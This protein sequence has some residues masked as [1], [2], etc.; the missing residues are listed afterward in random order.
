M[1]LPEFAMFHLPTRIIFGNGIA[2]DFSVELGELKA[3]KLF[4]VT[5]KTI[6]GLGLVDYMVKGLAANGIEVQGIF[7]EV[8]QDSSVKVVSRIAE[9]FN[10]VS[11]DSFLTIGGGS[12]IDSAKG[13]N[14]IAK[15]GGDLIKDYSGS[16]VLTEPLFPLIVVPTTAGTGSEVTNA[17]VIYDEE[18]KTKL[19]FI[20]RFIT[21]NLAVLDPNMTKSMPP[22]ITAFTGLDALTHAVEAFIDVDA[23]PFSDMYAKEAI[24]IITSHLI[25]ACINGDNLEERGWMAIG[26]TLAGVAFSHSECG[27]VHGIAHSL[28]AVHR[29]PHGIANAIILPYGM[30]YNLPSRIEKFAEL[31]K[32]LNV[33]NKE[34]SDEDNGKLAIENI[35]NFEEGV[36]KV[37]DLPLKLRDVGVLKENFELIAEKTL[38][39]GTSIYNPREETIEGVIEILNKAY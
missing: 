32:V 20:D 4:I 14:I 11:A 33:Y 18:T 9:L 5:D 19:E 36:S 13:A 35:R 6:M 25:N 12:V 23:T 27:I 30:E 38:Q 7:D 29:V 15:L 16:N 26:A 31:A 34:L 1:K 10:E 3:H 39:D 8:P 24:S 28:G 17:A 22:K 2:K 37:S 21:P